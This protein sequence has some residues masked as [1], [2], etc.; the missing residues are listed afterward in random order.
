MKIL[1]IIFV[2]NIVY[3]SFF[4][5]RMILVLK[6]QKLFASLLSML[7]VFVYLMGLKLVLD[8]LNDPWNIL[9][10]CIGWGTGVYLGSIIEEFLALGY[11]TVQVVLDSVEVNTPVILREKGY[12]VTSWL[13]NGKDG[14]RLVMNVLAKRRNERKLYQAI[15]ELSPKAFIISFEPKFFK[16]G[17]W[18]KRITK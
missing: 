18:T 7:E 1:L 2:I 11:V 16:G 9:A 13:A 12:G 10:Y 17:F 6:G 14:Q 3:V 4:T 5:L 15:H 8:N